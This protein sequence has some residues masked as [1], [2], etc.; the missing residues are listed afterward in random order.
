MS[1]FRVDPD[2]IRRALRLIL[3]PGQVTELRC[4]NAVVKGFKTTGTFSGYFDYDHID[5]LAKHCELIHSA[6]ACYFTPNP[7][8]PSL[9]ARSLNRARI[10]GHKEP[11]TAD[12]DITE[13]RWLLIDVDAM[14]PAGISAT[15]AERAATEGVATAIDYW[16]WERNFP[17]GII[18]DSGNGTHLMI[19]VR[20]PADDSGF[21]KRLLT[22]LAKE[23][24]TPQA[25]VDT[26]VHN[27][28]RIWKLPGTLVCKGDNCPEIGRE[29]RMSRIL[30]VC[31]NID[32][33]SWDD[34]ARS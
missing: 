1:R 30:Q 18:G 19:P 5:L 14:R 4:L 28:A 11:T 6:S 26:S 12:K 17:P 22:V 33:R 24:N 9:L 15:A 13:R 29:W 21:C 16:L 8:S 32:E 7:V 3:A 10:V 27:P 23:F 2:E 34:A 20:L 31:E 25:T